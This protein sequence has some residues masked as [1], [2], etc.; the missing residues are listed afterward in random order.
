LRG[1]PVTMSDCPTAHRRTPAIGCVRRGDVHLAEFLY[2]FLH[3]AGLV[4]SHMVTRFPGG[5]VSAISS[6]ASLAALPFA[7]SET[8][9]ARVRCGFPSTHAPDSSASPGL[10]GTSSTIGQLDRCWIHR[11]GSCAL[12]RESRRFLPNHRSGNWLIVGIVPAST[13]TGVN[14]HRALSSQPWLGKGGN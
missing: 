14:L 3:L 4:P 5:R 8:S 11:S 6:A 12:L 9:A 1:K 2:E 7:P 10:P 13:L